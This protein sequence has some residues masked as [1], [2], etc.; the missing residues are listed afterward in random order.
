MGYIIRKTGEN[1]NYE[2][3]VADFIIDSMVW[4]FSRLSSY[5][6]CPY[7]W[8][9][10]YVDCDDKEENFAAQFGG[11]I[12]KIIELYTKGELSIFELSQYYEDHYYEYVTCDP[13]PNKYVDMGQKYYDAGHDYFDNIDLELDKYQV[14]GVEKELRFKIGNYDFIGYIDLL[15]KDKL[16]GE[17]IILDHKSANIGVLKSGQI[18]KKD[19]EHFESFKK[20]LYLYSKPIIE[21]YGRVDKLKWNLFKE[22]RSIEIPWKK[23]EY[24]AAIKW[25]VNTIEMIKNEEEWEPSK[26][27]IKAIDEGKSIPYYCLFL[28]SQRNRCYW[29][30]CY[31]E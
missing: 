20:Q 30:S 29:K 9:K 13:P 12:H 1:L 15:L 18:A 24:D 11:Y 6:T 26:E 22:Q 27:L 3:R 25:A 5:Y 21:E 23:E 8:K 31:G 19:R 2:D 10:I 28:C 7:E 4:S 16:N 14:L 17:I